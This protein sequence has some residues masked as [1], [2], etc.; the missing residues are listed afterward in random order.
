M[1]IKSGCHGARAFRPRPGERPG[2]QNEGR[3]GDQGRPVANRFP[4]ALALAASFLRT[5]SR[6]MEGW[7]RPSAGVAATLQLP[8]PCGWGATDSLCGSRRDNRT[9][10][11][12]CFSCFLSSR[13]GAVYARPGARGSRSRGRRA[14]EASSSSDLW[15]FPKPRGAT[16]VPRN[17]RAEETR[18][19]PLL[20]GYSV[21]SLF[22]DTGPPLLASSAPNPHTRSPPSGGAPAPHLR[23]PS[24]SRSTAQR[25]RRPAP[26]SAI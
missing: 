10:P 8:R 6:Q 1:V 9:S 7:T 2:P 23:S 11:L 14:S 19:R 18:A 12:G 13:S 26:R 20:P 16:S 4:L 3:A 25:R 15:H 17:S 5:G 24:S 21:F 22:L